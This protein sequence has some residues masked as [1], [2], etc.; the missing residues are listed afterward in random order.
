MRL[1]PLVVLCLVALPLAAQTPDPTPPER[2]YPLGLGDVRE[3]RSSGNIQPTA[4]DRESVVGDTVV[5]GVAYRIVLRETFSSNGSVTGRILEPVRFD[6]ALARPLWRPPSG[7][8]IQL[9]PCR[10]DLPFP[11]PSSSVPCENGLYSGSATATVVVGTAVETSVK[12]FGGTFGSLSYAA[13]FGLYHQE[14]DASDRV[15]ELRFA[16]IAGVEYGEPDPLLPPI[17]RFPDPTPPEA[18]YPLHVGDVWEYTISVMPNP[19]ARY[20]R[21]QILRDSV[22]DGTTYFLRSYTGYRAD[23]SVVYEWADL[24]RFDTTRALP[25]LDHPVIE[26]QPA[27]LVCPFNL[28]FPSSGQPI[29][30]DYGSLNGGGLG[31]TVLVSGDAV[32]TAVRQFDGLGGASTY[33]AGLGYVAGVGEGS[34]AETTLVYARIDGVE[35]GQRIVGLPPLAGEGAPPS[36]ALALTAGPNPTVGP[37]VLTVTLP[38]PSALAVEAFDALG[39]RVHHATATSAAGTQTL[40]VD[41]SP[42]APGLYVVRVTAGREAATVRV[43]KR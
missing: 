43:V 35:V 16:R 1:A 2:Y 20:G 30:C 34:G 8:E 42:W 17:P 4:Y 19:F 24:V 38:A 11:D 28:P 37:L 22:I 18:Y 23:Y 5:V 27:A 10:L 21:Y 33:A 13:G 7:P 40:Y 39:R 9:V 12:S 41:A 14:Y 6:S 31:V 25:F 36:S 3:Y 32:V 26:D 29:Y 15:R